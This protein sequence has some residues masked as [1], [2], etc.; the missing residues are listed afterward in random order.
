M[1]DHTEYEEIIEWL[2]DK[3]YGEATIEKI[4]NRIRQYDQE[5]EHDSVMDS[6]ADGRMSLASI[7][8]EAL[9]DE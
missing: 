8:E 4:L 2:Q 5:T 1:A 6:I 7:I 9:A 3:G